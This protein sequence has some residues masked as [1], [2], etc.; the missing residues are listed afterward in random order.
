MPTAYRVESKD[1]VRAHNQRL[2]E[3]AMRA[4]GHFLEEWTEPML[5]RHLPAFERVITQGLVDRTPEMY[6]VTGPTP[7]PGRRRAAPPRP[8]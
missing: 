8:S 2:R 4:V 1:E 3:W 5:R 6:F 7:P